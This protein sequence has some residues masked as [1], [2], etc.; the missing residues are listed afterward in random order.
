MQNLPVLGLTANVTQSDIARFERAGVNEIMLKPLQVE[1]LIQ[2]IQ[3]M[4]NRT[5]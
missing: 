3:R 5:H 2:S 4:L 1:R